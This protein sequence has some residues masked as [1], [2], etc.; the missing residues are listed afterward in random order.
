MAGIADEGN[1]E[2][3]DHFVPVCYLKRWAYRR[4][5]RRER[6]WKIQWRQKNG[7]RVCRSKI[8]DVACAKGY[9]QYRSSGECIDKELNEQ[10][11]KRLAGIVAR[12]IEGELSREDALSV[13]VN[14][15]VRS[16]R[17]MSVLQGLSSRHPQTRDW[18]D[19]EHRDSALKCM[20][21]NA[22]QD[23]RDFLADMHLATA[24]VDPTV[25]GLATSDAPVVALHSL[26]L[27][28]DLVL[29]PI[30]P[31]YLWIWS[32]RVLRNFT[33][34]ATFAEKLNREI[35]SF[36]QDIIVLPPTIRHTVA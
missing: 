15:A 34:N 13:T 6:N 3:K 5:G 20:Q 30:D 12:S 9:Y 17:T 31:Q 28:E 14:L 22:P 18:T 10:I 25:G 23:I 29:L 27:G 1:G 7:A 33:A 8:R 4:P 2:R 36:S 21:S 16:P 26:E 19:D 35:E 32:R 11:E 24:S